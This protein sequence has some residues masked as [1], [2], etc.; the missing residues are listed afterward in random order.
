MTERII[1]YNDNLP[2][3]ISYGFFREKFINCTDEGTAIQYT[4]Y[5]SPSHR[6]PVP[7]SK[8]T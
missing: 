8:A 3:R 1:L 7:Q 5:Y 6:L 4:S 2:D